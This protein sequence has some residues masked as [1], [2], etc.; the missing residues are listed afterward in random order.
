LKTHQDENSNYKAQ[1]AQFDSLVNNPEQ[2]L[3]ALAAVNP[4]YKRFLTA[5]PTAQPTGEPQE[6]RTLEDLQ[7]VI[8]ARV[9]EQTAPIMQERQQRQVYEA[10]VPKVKAQIAEAESWPMFKEAKAEILKALQSNPTWG[11]KDAYQSVVIPKLAANRDTVRQSVLDELKTRPHSTTVT[12]T[13]SGRTSQGGEPL[14]TA[15]IVRNAARSI[16][17]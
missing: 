11:L 9:A 2:L 6:I 13:V 3:S 14:D 5:Q 10:A 15:D 4:A 1:V 8:D 16:K 12:S 17:D 7:R